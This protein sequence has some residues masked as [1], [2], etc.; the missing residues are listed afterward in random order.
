MQTHSQRGRTIRGKA[1]ATSS[2]SEVG[3]ITNALTYREGGGPGG[4]R[5]V[6]LG[7]GHQLSLLHRRQP[8]RCISVVQF[9]YF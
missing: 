6:V 5:L 7:E 1:A 4:Y 2:V 9:Y 8:A 3:E